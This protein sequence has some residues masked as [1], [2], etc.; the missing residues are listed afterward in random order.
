MTFVLNSRPKSTAARRPQPAAR[1]LISLAAV[2]V[3]VWFPVA[4]AR[5]EIEVADLRV[6]HLAVGKADLGAGGLQQS[7]RE[8]VPELVPD[9]RARQLDGVP[10][11]AATVAPSIQDD[12]HRSRAPHCV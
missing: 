9:G 11:S 5:A 8:R 3:S 7:P 1:A 6:P 10:V 2:A 4:P 12:E